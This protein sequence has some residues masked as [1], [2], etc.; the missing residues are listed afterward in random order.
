[1][2]NF[3]ELTDKETGLKMV[4]NT[5]EISIAVE[6]DTE[7]SAVIG[8]AEFVIEESYDQLKNLLDVR[9]EET[10]RLEEA[11]R[12]GS[13]GSVINLVEDIEDFANNPVSGSLNVLADAA[14]A[15]GDL[16]E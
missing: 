14:E 12:E 3:I 7:V 16:F 10:L 15:V 8:G 6:E 1:M 4:V 5:K 9:T 2:S 11:L 13:T